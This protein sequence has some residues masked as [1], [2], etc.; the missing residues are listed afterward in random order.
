MVFC[1]TVVF[2]GTYTCKQNITKFKQKPSPFKLC[3]KTRKPFENMFY[4]YISATSTAVRRVKHE[5]LLSR[6][7]RNLENVSRTTTILN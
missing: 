4:R 7:T 5:M 2:C 3:T 6:E 1:C